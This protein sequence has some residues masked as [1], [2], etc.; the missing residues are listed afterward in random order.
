M[1]SRAP[2]SAQLRVFHQNITCSMHTFPSRIES[3]WVLAEIK[4]VEDTMT[5]APSQG[6]GLLVPKEL[7]FPSVLTKQCVVVPG[8]VD[9]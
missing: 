1:R 7:T 5:Y 4:S 2:F 3:F 6:L 8:M 9:R